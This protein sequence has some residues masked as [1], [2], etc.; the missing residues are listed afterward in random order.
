MDI[1]GIAVAITGG[2]SGLGAGVAKLLASQG[3]QGRHSRP[4]R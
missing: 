2:A 3:R 4:K 1:N